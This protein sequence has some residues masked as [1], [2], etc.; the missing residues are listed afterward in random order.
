VKIPPNNVM[1]QDPMNQG[2]QPIKHWDLRWAPRAVHLK[3]HPLKGWG[4]RLWTA[5][6]HQAPQG[7]YGVQA[8]YQAL[9]CMLCITIM[10]PI[11]LHCTATHLYVLYT[12]TREFSEFVKFMKTWIYSVFCRIL[13]NFSTRMPFWSARIQENW[14]IF[15]INQLF[16]AR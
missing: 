6:D 14:A 16:L 5:V 11:A 7:L 3:P 12:R 10:H 13:C 8:S 4:C 1:D 2:A 9:H 15:Q